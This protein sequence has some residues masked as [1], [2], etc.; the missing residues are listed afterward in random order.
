MFR[1]K[2]APASTT[3]EGKEEKKETAEDKPVVLDTPTKDASPSALRDLLE[4]NLKWSQ[5]IYE[6]NRKINH[7]LFWIVLSGWTR[8]LIILAPIILAIIFLPP[9]VQ[10]FW[11]KYGETING[12]LSATQKMNTVGSGNASLEQIL[13]MLPLDS[14][15]QQQIKQILK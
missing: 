2:T 7:K 14:A 10:S 8:V 12:V 13:Q 11:Q 15:K 9:Y 1:H 3:E 4:K 6:Q 5:I